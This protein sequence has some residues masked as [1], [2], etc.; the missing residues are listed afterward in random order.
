MYRNKFQSGFLPIYHSVG[1]KTMENWRIV[2]QN[3]HVKRLVDEDIKSYVCEIRGCNA[4][5]T[6]MSCPDTQNKSLGI[7]LPHLTIILKNLES[8]FYF[9]VEVRDEDGTKHRLKACSFNTKS[10][11]GQF[12]CTMP[13][14]LQNGWNRVHLDLQDFLNKGFSKIY[15]ETLRVTLHASCRVRCVY[16]TDRQYTEDQTPEIYKLFPNQKPQNSKTN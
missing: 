11:S 5:T 16:F 4:V 14:Q 12:N 6:Y 2:A 3:G 15:R 1:W 8:P 10:N 9:E 7:T 13:L